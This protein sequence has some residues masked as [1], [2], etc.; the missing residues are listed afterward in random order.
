M[1][2]KVATGINASITLPTGTLVKTDSMAYTNDRRLINTT[3]FVDGEWDTFQGDGRSAL[4]AFS[5]HPQYDATSTDPDIVLDNDDAEEYTITVATG[6]TIVADFVKFRASFTA[7]KK[8]GQTRIS[9]LAQQSG[10]ATQTWDET[11]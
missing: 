5:G 6:C 8:S 10:A 2:I 4:L 3:G 7:D 1:A 11:A 9:V